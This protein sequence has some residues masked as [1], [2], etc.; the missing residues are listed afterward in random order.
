MPRV[1]AE[2]VFG[3]NT[4]A[5]FHGTAPGAIDGGFENESLA[6]ARRRE[7]IQVIHGSRD[8][9]VAAMSFRND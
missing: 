4:N 5:Y 8:A 9:I 6:G 2:A 1:A 7:K 3:Y